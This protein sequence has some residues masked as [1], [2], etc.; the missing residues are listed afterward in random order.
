M[1]TI[2]EDLLERDLQAK[3]V[4][5]WAESGLAGILVHIPNEGKRNRIDCAGLAALGIVAGAPDLLLILPNA[6]THLI[7]LKT[8]I[9]EMSRQQRDFA[10]AVQRLG[11]TFSLVRSLEEFKESVRAA[12]AFWACGSVVDF[13]AQVPLP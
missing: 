2:S 1:V 11:H 9:G 6:R 3:C 13:P 5:W 10:S 12:M 8:P 7:E 4:R